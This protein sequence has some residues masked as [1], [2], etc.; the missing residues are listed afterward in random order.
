MGLGGL[1]KGMKMGV[2]Y[3][4]L[5]FGRL[6]KR[7]KKGHRHIPSELTVFRPFEVGEK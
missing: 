6:E 3:H 4:F 1:W 5:L 2:A 7:K